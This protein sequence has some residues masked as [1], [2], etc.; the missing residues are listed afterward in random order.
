MSNIM[1][2]KTV[3]IF[4]PNGDFS[5]IKKAYI[6]TDR[7]EI[8][9]I[10]RSVIRDNASN[11]LSFN[12]IYILVDSVRKE[13]PEIYIGKGNVARRVLNHNRSLDFWNTVFAIGLRD[14]EFSEADTSYLEHRFIKMVRELR[15]ATLSRNIQMPQCPNLNAMDIADNDY[16]IGVTK[17]I[18]SELGLM[19]FQPRGDGEIFICKD[20]RG[21]IGKGQYVGDGFLLHAGA[22]CKLELQRNFS[23][24]RRDELIAERVLKKSGEHYVLKD[25]RLFSSVS[26]AASLVLGR[27]ANGW[28]EW[29]N[30]TGKTLDEIKRG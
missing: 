16:Y 1:H 7:I 29:K 23:F 26:Q 17:N 10:S 2:P 11:L 5:S 22:C 8:T 20:T 6:R 27:K 9:Q 3:E 18:L 30:A 24:S 21:N 4:L 14:G 25:D 12:G 13:I 15:T 19:C 28:I